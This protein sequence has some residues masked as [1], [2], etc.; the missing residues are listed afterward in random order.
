MT[1][2]RSAVLRSPEFFRHDTGEHVERAA[3]LAA[4]DRELGRRNL[5][6]DRA[7]VYFGAADDE[8]ILRV[9]TAAHLRGL[10][11]FARAGGGWLDS[12]TVVRPESMDVAR[13]A[14][15]AATTA[16]DAIL[17]GSIDRAFIL[18]RP[19]GHHATPDRAMG[20]CLLN[21][22]AIAAAQ[23]IAS[24]LGRVAI[25]DWDVHHG[26]GTQDIFYG[27]SDVLFCSLHQSPLYPGTGSPQETG[28]GT[29]V[30]STVNVPL[31]AGT[32]DDTFL[33]AFRSRI[34]PAIVT[35][36]P[37]LL[38][39]SAGYDAHEQDP[40][41]GMRLTDAGFRELMSETVALAERVCDGRLLVVLEGGYDVSAL[42]RCVADAIEI[43]D[44]QQATDTAVFPA[45]SI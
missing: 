11:E 26:N 6:D 14:A 25:L 20:F 31:P 37:Q 8:A 21:S 16:V 13:L 40:V 44:G 35:F 10:E 7:T 24:G 2:L 41:G 43:L 23:A 38:L 17:D 22:V 5:L 34:A 32:T 45:S 36:R 3:R 12:D 33:A 30:G 29:G 18:A 39:I 15:G 27:R 42:A 4:I 28:R 1:R 9:H 19:P